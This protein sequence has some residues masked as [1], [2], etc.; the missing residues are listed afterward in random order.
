MGV[1]RTYMACMVY[2]NMIVMTIPVVFS[3]ICSLRERSRKIPGLQTTLQSLNITVY[4]DLTDSIW[5][6]GL[7]TI[8]SNR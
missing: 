7:L 4:P 5:T 2:N 8:G 3:P 6:I 1:G